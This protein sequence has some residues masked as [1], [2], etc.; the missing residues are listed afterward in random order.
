MEDI[1]CPSCGESELE[2]WHMDIYECP[3][4]GND[5]IID[6]GEMAVEYETSVKTGKL[7]KRNKE[8]HSIWYAQKCRCGWDS[9]SEK[10]E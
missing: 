2:L 9:Y 10:Y 5:Q 7:L 4:C 1:I 6:Y 3:E 8:G